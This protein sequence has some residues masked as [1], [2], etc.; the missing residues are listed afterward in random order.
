MSKDI[1]FKL[2]R[3]TPSTMSEIQAYNREDNREF[4]ITFVPNQ[5]LYFNSHSIA[6]RSWVF[7]QFGQD[8]QYKPETFIND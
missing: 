8:V 5:G 1:G 3:F 4:T 7:L 6:F 2:V